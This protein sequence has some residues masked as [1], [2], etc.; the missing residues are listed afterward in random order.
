M[1][2]AEERSQ[3]QT[4]VTASGELMG[5][6]SPSERAEA[7]ANSTRAS[8]FELLR[9]HQERWL[10]D[11]DEIARS[12]IAEAVGPVPTDEL[13]SEVGGTMVDGIESA[14]W[15]LAQDSTPH[16]KRE[17]SYS[18][19]S[20]KLTVYS[21]NE[22]SFTPRQ[23][24]MD[25]IHR[26][27][28]AVIVNEDR[29]WKMR[30]IRP[31]SHEYENDVATWRRRFGL[32]GISGASI[33]RRLSLTVS[34]NGVYYLVERDENTGLDL[35]QTKVYHLDSRFWDS[36]EGKRVLAL[37]GVDRELLEGFDD[38]RMGDLVRHVWSA[39]APVEAPK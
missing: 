34:K 32:S 15:K 3:T 11:V 20:G 37:Y 36:A 25:N 28:E 24:S 23:P 38:S 6:L 27:V 19:K 8:G 14:S 39:A 5:P 26:G 31:N 13:T 21:G 12:R 4:I 18:F 16:Y 9:Q 29:S 2:G 22:V 33:N 17:L 10:D 30:P 1:P 35:L 7:A